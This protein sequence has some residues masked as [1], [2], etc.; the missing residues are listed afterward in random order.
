MK[1]EALREDRG[2]PQVAA[3]S[4]ESLCSVLLLRFSHLSLPFMLVVLLQLMQCAVT[5][6]FFL[7][8]FSFLRRPSFDCLPV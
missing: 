7:L 3:D 1:E 8:P 5:V 6:R 2:P 4:G